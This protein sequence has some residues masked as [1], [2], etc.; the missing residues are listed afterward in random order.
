MSRSQT[1]WGFTLQTQHFKQYLFS[2][3]MFVE[4]TYGGHGKELH[5]AANKLPKWAL[6]GCDNAGRSPI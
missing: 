4:M 2:S 6:G 3:Q 1:V 5:R